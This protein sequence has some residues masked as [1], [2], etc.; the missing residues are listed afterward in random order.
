MHTQQGFSLIEA[1]VSLLVLS[2]GI[3]GLGQL[4]AGLWVNAAQLHLRDA[5]LLIASNHSEI[6]EIQ[7]I[8]PDSSIS[9]PPEAS[10]VYSADFD[11]ETLTTTQDSTATSHTTVSWQGR[12]GMDALQL[13]TTLNTRF[14]PIDTRWLLTHH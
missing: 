13:G 10:A 3:L 5:A 1:L 11:I 6:A 8:M 9:Y 14:K 2:I 12:T 4:Q 7:L